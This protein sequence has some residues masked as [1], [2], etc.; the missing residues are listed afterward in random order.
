MLSDFPFLEQSPLERRVSQRKA[1]DCG[2]ACLAMV[3]NTD[4]ETARGAFITLGLDRPRSSG[5]MPY[6]SNFRELCRA[7]ELLGRRAVVHRF[8]DWADIEGPSIVAVEAPGTTPD[9]WHWVFA[10]RH[11]DL[12][13][14]V[15]DPAQDVIAAERPVGGGAMAPLTVHAPLDAFI[16]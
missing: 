3:A 4:Y 2:V 16:R 7:A 13:A 5:R 9:N 1:H 11:P 6:S 14:V 15:L 10:D 8:R 12:G